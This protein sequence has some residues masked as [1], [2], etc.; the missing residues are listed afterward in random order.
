SHRPQFLAAAGRHGDLGPVRP[1]HEANARG[2]AVHHRLHVGDVDRR[3]LGDDAA[4][5]DAGR[6]HVLGAQVPTLH[7]AGAL[8]RVHAEHR[9]LFAALVAG[10]NHHSNALADVHRHHTTSG[11]SETIFM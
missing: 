3:L 4:L 6:A 8:P 5:A 2:P 7:D 11:A 9:A 1:H 10:D